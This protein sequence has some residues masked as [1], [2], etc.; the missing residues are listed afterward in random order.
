MK[1]ILTIL[2]VLISFLAQSQDIKPIDPIG[3]KNL[4][5]PSFSYWLNDS[6]VWI[7]K[8]ATYQWTKL[9]SM[10]KTKYMVDSLA[11]SLNAQLLNR[12]LKSDTATYDAT[13]YWVLQRGYTGSQSLSIDSTN[14]V[15]RIGISGGNTIKFK[16]ENTDAQTLSFTSPNLSIS[17][18]NSVNISGINTDAQNLSTTGTAGNISIS[19]GNT[20]TLNVNDADANATNEIQDLSG[21][22]STLSGYQI[23]LS[24]DATPVTL[25][26]EADGSITN[27]GSLTVAAGTAT[28][29]IINSN[30]SG[31]TGVTL[32]VDGT[33]LGIT[34]TG[35]N[36]TL[37]NLKPDQTVVL[38]SGTGISATGTYPNFTITNTA[39]N[40]DAQNLSLGAVTTTTQPINISGGTGVTLP[41]A[42]TTTAGLFTSADKTK[43]DGVAAGATNYSHPTGFTNQ[44]ASALSGAN[45]ISQVNVNT[46]GHVTGVQSRGLTL[47]DLSFSYPGA[48][49]PLSTGT[50]WGTSITDNSANWNTAF[51]W[52]NHATAGYYNA[53]N[54]IAGTHYQA[55]LTNPTTGTGTTNYL[56]KW[57]GL[58]TQG[59][60]QIF[61]NGV[62]IGIGTTTELASK[63]NILSIGV[64]SNEDFE[65]RH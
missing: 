61:D 28:T 9:A 36:I 58:T 54:F 19:G 22:G 7:Y 59:N 23:A 11:N 24:G 15:F 45:V 27:E 35:N 14:R 31:Q 12:Q 6:S 3:F 56:T 39:P 5:S 1:R 63:V 49:I 50:G 44:P 16:D 33:N 10:K 30:T 64:I 40:T 51:G 38:T 8:G 13:K 21:S 17:G 20:I 53:T 41:A 48:G 43:L 32:T 65:T 52:G 18:G 2:I 55:P 46:E 57:T 25:P 37:S 34:E 60:S 42:T 26:N 62:S 47:N 29:S 4:Q